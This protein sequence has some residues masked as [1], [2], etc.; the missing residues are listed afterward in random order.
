ML[1]LN[2]APTV[3]KNIAIFSEELNKIILKDLNFIFKQVNNAKTII[4]QE[5]S[6]IKSLNKIYNSRKEIRDVWTANKKLDQFGVP[7]RYIR[8]A[9]EL[10]AANAKT[11]WTQTKDDIRIVILKNENL[12]KEDIKYIKSILNDNL[13]LFNVLNRLNPKDNKL[14]NLIRRYV[15]KYKPNKS[16]YKKEGTISID[17]EMYTIEGDILYITGLVFRKR[18]EIQ[19]KTTDPNLTGNLQLKLIGNQLRI[20]NCLEIDTKPNNYENVIGIDKNYINCFDTNTENSYGEGLNKLQNSY[21]DSLDQMNA[22]RKPY[23]E[24][25]QKLKEELKTTTDP[26]KIKKLQGKINHILKYNL[27][28]VKYNRKKNRLKENLTKHINIAVK[29]LIKAEEAKEIATENLN[30]TYSS[31]KKKIGKKVKH[32]LSNW[33]KGIMRERLEYIGSLNEVKITKVNAAFTS[34]ICPKCGDLGSRKGGCISLPMWQG[35][36]VRYSC[37]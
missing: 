11:M 21:T 33:V 22:K 16:V 24:H 15:R 14:D 18:Y 20:S 6:S 17:Q 37:R 13:L 10:V 5:F 32:K 34:Q 26:V 12:T 31:K 19:L 25:I 9:I 23:Y 2:E 4:A 36:E 1:N 7:K 8:N 35:R 3:K 27:G 29:D 28:K 30:F